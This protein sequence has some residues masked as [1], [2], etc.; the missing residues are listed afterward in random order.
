MNIASVKSDLLA[1]FANSECC[2][3]R[4]PSEFDARDIVDTATVFGPAQDDSG[5]YSPVWVRGLQNDIFP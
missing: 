2:A 1:D 5:R 3:V 4:G